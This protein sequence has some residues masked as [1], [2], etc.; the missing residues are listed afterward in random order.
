MIRKYAFWGMVFLLCSL[1]PASQ[2]A[3]PPG[4]TNGCL[5]VYGLAWDTVMTVDTSGDTTLS[6]EKDSVVIGWNCPDTADT[7]GVDSS[8]TD[9]KPVYEITVVDS[10]LEVQIT[11]GYYDSTCAYNAVTGQQCTVTYVPVDSVLTY[12]FV[13]DTLVTWDCPDTSGI[14]TVVVSD[15]G[16]GSMDSGVSYYRYVADPNA[17]VSLKI[18]VSQATAGQITV[19]E[20]P[21]AMANGDD[22]CVKA[23]DIDL[24]DDLDAS[25]KYASLKISYDPGKLGN[26][27]E[28]DL[29][30]YYLNGNVW[31]IVPGKHDVDAKNNT[32]T[33]T[34]T[35]FSTYGIFDGGEQTASRPADAHSS[36]ITIMRAFPGHAGNHVRIS[37]S[38]P[39]ATNVELH[40]YDVAGKL[41]KTI[42]NR[43]CQSGRHAAFWSGTNARSQSVSSG[44]YLLRMVAGNQTISKKV[45]LLK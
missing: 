18:T 22:P 25:L 3:P 21:D 37:F 16:W 23:V 39:K 1:A 28:K 9:C 26:A 40:V 45:N 2:T 33:V 6:V 12:V 34:V 38:L 4:G 29:R 20:K 30:V 11:G 19:E 10:V 32:I 44:V 43:T 41:V 5:P 35:H 42:L 27:K 7:A 8:D 15:S 31:E 24:S 17:G 14:T 13:Y 36:G